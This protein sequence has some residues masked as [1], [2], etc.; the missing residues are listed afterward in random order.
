[1]A[2]RLRWRGFVRAA[3]TIEERVGQPCWHLFAVGDAKAHDDA[4]GGDGARAVP[5]PVGADDVGRLV[6]VRLL[7]LLDEFDQHVDGAVGRA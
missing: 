5:V 6:I 1:M 4:E 2:L 7:T 3:L